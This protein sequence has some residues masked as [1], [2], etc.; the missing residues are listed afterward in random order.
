M[1]N[2]W[3]LLVAVV[4]GLEASALYLGMPPVWHVINGFSLGGLFV[5]LAASD[6]GENNNG[7]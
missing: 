2:K 7:K 1:V 4:F 6:S 5:I 3:W